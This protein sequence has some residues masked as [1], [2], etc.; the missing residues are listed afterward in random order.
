M[1][2]PNGACAA[3]PLLDTGLLPAVVWHCR[4]TV[5]FVMRFSFGSFGRNFLIA[6]ALAGAASRP[7]AAENTAAVAFLEKLSLSPASTPVLTLCH[8]F[9]CAYRNQFVITPAR[10]SFI[11]ATL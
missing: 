4:T 11:R 1:P 9:D 6:A 5:I 2:L 3:V 10:L 7:A 8:G